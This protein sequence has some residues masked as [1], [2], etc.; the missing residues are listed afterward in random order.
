MLR[1]KNLSPSFQII[2]SDSLQFSSDLKS[3][4]DELWQAALSFYDSRLFNGQIF[5]AK[6]ITENEIIGTFVE[7]KYLMAQHLDPRLKTQLNIRPVSVLGFLTCPEGVLFGKRQ[8]WV[9]TRP[10]EWGFLPSE[11]L[12]ADTFSH[13]GKIDYVKAFLVALKNELNIEAHF[14]TDLQHSFLI[15]EK[16]VSENHYSLVMQADIALS[17]FAIKKAHLE[18]PHDEY[19]LIKAIPNEQLEAFLNEKSGRDI[20]IANYILNQN[21]YLTLES[22]CA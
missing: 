17:S 1:I 19:E 10:N 4:V 6:Q 7:Y 12:G 14:L 18:A 20:N 13:D 11:Y 16:S 3:R 9:A 22:N 21:G 2:Q 8:N 5:S 15:E